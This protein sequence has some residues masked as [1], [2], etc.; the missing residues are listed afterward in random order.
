MTTNGLG[1][2]NAAG[3]VCGHLA[4]RSRSILSRQWQPSPSLALNPRQPTSRC[5]VCMPSDNELPWR[6]LT[7]SVFLCSSIFI[8]PQVR[9][10]LRA[11]R[12]AL[13]ESIRVTL[14]V[15]TE[16]YTRTTREFLRVLFETLLVDKFDI[17]LVDAA[18]EAFFPL[19]C[20]YQVIGTCFVSRGHGKSF[21]RKRSACI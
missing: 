5:Q 17:S 18:A 1:W 6:R 7:A 10:N 2:L 4:V 9:S 14:L 13:V 19:I 21:S 16:Q 12:P 8:L 20:L 3:S 15:S 11:F